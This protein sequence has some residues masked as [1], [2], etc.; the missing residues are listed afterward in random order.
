MGKRILVTGGAGFQH[1]TTG[2]LNI[3]AQTVTLQ[4]GRNVTSGTAGLTIGGAVTQTGT[5]VFNVNSNYNGILG[6]AGRGRGTGR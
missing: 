3:G 5:S 4:A 1:T 6:S 2:A